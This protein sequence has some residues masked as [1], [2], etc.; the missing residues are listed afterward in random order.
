VR[1][2]FFFVFLAADDVAR[3]DSARENLTCRLP[4]VRPPIC[5]AMS[6]QDM[7]WPCRRMIRASSSAEYF[8][9]APAI[10]KIVRWKGE[11]RWREEKRGAEKLGEEKSESM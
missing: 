11:R 8:F 6:A 4:A 5:W 9:A 3:A 10:S 1:T 2:F 7:P